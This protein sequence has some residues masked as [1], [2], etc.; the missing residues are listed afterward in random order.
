MATYIDRYRA[1]EHEQVWAELTALSD[2]VRTEPLLS[3]AMA[4]ARETMAWARQNVELLIPRLE[5]IGYRFGFYEEGAP[6]PSYP[7][8]LVP[9]PPDITTQLD[10]LET[11]VG[12]L[13]LSLR[14]WY[15]AVGAVDFMGF[16][17]QWRAIY[18]DPL[19][20]NELE[21]EYRLDSYRDWRE[22]CDEEGEEE[23]GPYEYEFAP[24]FYHKANV[25]GGAPYGIALPCLTADAT[26]ENE[27]HRTTFVDYLRIC[28]Q[29]GGFP[30]LDPNIAEVNSTQHI[31]YLTEG[32]LPL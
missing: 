1:G 32:L 11:A 13:P 30:G 14:A 6:V 23:M 12:A 31:A 29:W 19:V 15:E 26:A 8:P 3:E 20:V 16:H 28:F 2:A 21:L 10:T 18:P 4:V 27:P 25:S 7:G 22:E 17:A 9:P 5:A 24:D